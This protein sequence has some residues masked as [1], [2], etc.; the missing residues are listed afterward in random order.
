[1]DMV[2][3]GT[4]KNVLWTRSEICRT[5]VL[6][7][8]RLTITRG[9]VTNSMQKTVPKK[10]QTA[11]A[12]SRPHFVC[13]NYVFPSRAGCAVFCWACF[14]RFSPVRRFRKISSGTLFHYLGLYFYFVSSSEDSPRSFFFFSSFSFLPLF[15]FFSPLFSRSPEKSVIS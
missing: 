7:R 10:T 1:M 8:P 13:S 4:K 6:R 14:F 11:E 5:G 15:F 9:G 3:M 2:V 12:V